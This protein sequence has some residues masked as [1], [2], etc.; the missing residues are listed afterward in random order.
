MKS[1]LV[2]ALLAGAAAADPVELTGSSPTPTDA[3]R[4][5]VAEACA[6]V[7]GARCTC[8]VL[9]TIAAPR[10]GVLMLDTVSATWRGRSYALA[11]WQDGSWQRSANAIDVDRMGVLL[12][13]NCCDSHAGAPW[14]Q[15]RAVDGRAILH[16]GQD[17]W[18]TGKRGGGWTYFEDPH[19]IWS[20]L[21]VC[22]GAG[23]DRV[24]VA[25]CLRPAHPTYTL[26]GARIETGC[27]GATLQSY[28]L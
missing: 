21:L 5:W 26:S 18:R 4:A 11:V 20:D 8:R 24:P 12:A 10:A 6:A 16:V 28:A 22:T 27:T 19:A 2:L 13:S 25:H 3:C 9:D 17:V 1:L 23:C 14:F 15:L 7:D